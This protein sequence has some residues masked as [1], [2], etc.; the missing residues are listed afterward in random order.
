MQDQVQKLNS[1]GIQSV[2]LGSAQFDKPAE[3]RALD[4]TSEE[5][6]IFVT[7]EWITKPGNQQKLQVLTGEKKLALIAIDEAHLVSEWADFRTA[8][9]GLRDLKHVFSDIPIM[10]VSATATAEVEDKIQ[11]LLRNP[12]TQKASINRPNITLNVEELHPDKATEPAMQ[13]AVRAAE[14]AG[15]SSSIVFT[16]TS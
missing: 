2:Y 4:P 1:L 9:S 7:P 5:S 15:T 10:A 11:Q 8:F 3:S 13:F 6:L 16:Q 14:I 12:I